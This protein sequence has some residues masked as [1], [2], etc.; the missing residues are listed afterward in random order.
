MAEYAG[1]II[2]VSLPLLRSLLRPRRKKFANLDPTQF[3]RVRSRSYNLNDAG[4]EAGLQ[5]ENIS[6][7]TN[8]TVLSSASMNEG[9]NGL[10]AWHEDENLPAAQEKR[11]DSGRT[12]Y[13]HPKAI[14]RPQ[15]R[16]ELLDGNLCDLSNGSQGGDTSSGSAFSH[17]SSRH[18]SP[19]SFGREE[20]D[21][22]EQLF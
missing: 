19:H 6:K 2:V 22:D 12:L 3:T 10:G 15:S 14:L 21:N 1:S 9:G 5:L 18:V 8:E 20:S 7:S 4:Y 11:K 17:D 13:L 16:N